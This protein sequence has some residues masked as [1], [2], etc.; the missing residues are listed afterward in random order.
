MSIKTR[1]ENLEEK[2]KLTPKPVWRS[3]IVYDPETDCC[4]LNQYEDD[5]LVY[6]TLY[7]PG[8]DLRLL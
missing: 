4:T 1:V 8:M 2:V 6:S 7:G 3:E 5:R